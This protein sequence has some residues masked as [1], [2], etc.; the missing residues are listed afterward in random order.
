MSGVFGEGL[1]INSLM[2]IKAFCE[3]YRGVRRTVLAFCCLWTSAAVGVGLWAMYAKGLG[4]SDTAFLTAVVALMQTPIVFYFH[5]RG[6][7]K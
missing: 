3:K 7:G 6:N 2:D 5:T 1:G 4:A